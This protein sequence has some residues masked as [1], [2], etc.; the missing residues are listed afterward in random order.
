MKFEMEFDWTGSE[1][2]IVESHDFSKIKIIQEF[3]EYQ[4]E[5]DWVEYEDAD[6]LEV[7]LEED[8]EEEEVA[9]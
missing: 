8:T 9:E 2:I 6:E 1:K 4:I 7:E 5:T 3:I